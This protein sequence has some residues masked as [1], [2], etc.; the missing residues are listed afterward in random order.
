[1][2]RASVDGDDT[3]VGGLSAPS[4]DGTIRREMKQLARL[5]WP[6]VLQ[7]GSQQIMLACD[8]I[9]VGRLG[10]FEM[11]V[12]SLFTVLFT[13]PGASLPLPCLYLALPGAMA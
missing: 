2:K 3:N 5:T 13:P 1:M 6:I 12:G 7:M 11:T 9:Y 10:R 8:L 4:A